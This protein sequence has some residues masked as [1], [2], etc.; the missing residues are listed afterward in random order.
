MPIYTVMDCI[1]R[2]AVIL[3]CLTTLYSHPGAAVAS[4]A[5]RMP[6]AAPVTTLHPASA[7]SERQIATM[8]SPDEALDEQPIATSEDGV[9]DELF[10]TP[11]AMPEDQK[12][13]ED[14]NDS[15]SLVHKVVPLVVVPVLLT[16]LFSLMYCYYRRSSPRLVLPNTLRAGAL[17]SLNNGRDVLRPPCESGV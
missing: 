14:F 12:T 16:T 9:N 2:I 8:P 4:S 5:Y 1:R 10:A 3:L 7:V 15:S 6:Q 13:R 17:G 11:T